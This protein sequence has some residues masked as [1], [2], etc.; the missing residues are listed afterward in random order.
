MNVSEIYT[1]SQLKPSPYI[2]VGL[3]IYFFYTTK[4]DY[5]EKIISE[6]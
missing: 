4:Y 3:Y 1:E 5:G 2:I 6:A